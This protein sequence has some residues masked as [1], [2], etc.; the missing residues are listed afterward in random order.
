VALL[1]HEY[2]PH[3]IGGIGSFSQDLADGL[4]GFGIQVKVIAGWGRSEAQ[5]VHQNGVEIVW[6]PRGKLAPKHLWFQLRNLHTISRELSDC[7][8]IHGQDC[9]AFPL[10]E[11]LKKKGI[12]TPSVVTFHTNPREEL[13][14]TLQ[15]IC[16]GG[17]LTDFA[18]YVAGFPLWDL[19][20][21]RHSKCANRLVAV[22]ES[23]RE[24]LCADYK[25]S[26]NNISVIH[27]CVNSE[28]LNSQIRTRQQSAEDSKV[29]LVCAGRLY[30]GKGVLQL[31]EIVRDLVDR[32]G[33]RNF[34]LHVYGSG[35]LESALK[36]KLSSSGMENFVQIHGFVQ[37]NI[38]INAMAASDIVCVPSG[39]E[40]CPVVLMEAMTLGKPVLAFNLPFSQEFLKGYE[41]LLAVNKAD[42]SQKLSHL[43]NTRTDRIRLGQAM[44]F[45]SKEF[46]QYKVAFAYK[47]LYEELSPK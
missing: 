6:L 32:L 3:I 33:V 34:K 21:L 24:S 39:Y 9:A 45:R 35:P 44:K 18:T 14:L 38:L 11:R 37:H 27:N 4:A 13:W 23:L 25:I 15:S 22:S 20:I 41:M 43:I 30:Y 12:S 16:H 8:V 19:T 40:A 46:T 10:L 5:R 47:S 29:G 42:Y 28:N 36:S 1:T 2:P 31:V 26:T 7:S 17:S